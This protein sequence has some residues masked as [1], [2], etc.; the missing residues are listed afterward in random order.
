MVKGEFEEI[1]QQIGLT[2]AE[3]CV[4]LAAL[5]G[6]AQPASSIATRSGLKR[7]H[8]YN[9]LATLL[10]K[11]LVQEFERGGSK[12]FLATDPTGLLTV[13]EQAEE[14]LNRTREELITILPLLEKLR[15]PIINPPRVRFFQGLDGV[16][17]V[18][19]D[20]IAEPG[21]PV[22]AFLDLQKAYIQLGPD[23]SAFI[24]EYAAQRIERDI[25]LYAIVPQESLDKEDKYRGS[26]GA[27]MRRDF[28]TLSGYQPTAEIFI[29]RGRVS[30]ITTWQQKIGL[31]IEDQSIFNTFYELHRILWSILPPVEAAQPEPRPGPRTR[32][33]RK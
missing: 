18:L 27:L 31:T 21:Q 15:S 33:V 24:D 5:Q 19:D 22:Y 16:R 28:R 30:I 9:V 25:W 26:V 29:Y 4:Y 32:G 17:E 1:L 2:D 23:H 8:T 14:G 11:G 10:E 3:C 12:Q 13:L 20:T 6:G 7:G